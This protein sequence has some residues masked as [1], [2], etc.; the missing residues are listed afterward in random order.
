MGKH[1]TKVVLLMFSKSVKHGEDMSFRICGRAGWV[2]SV[3]NLEK[4]LGVA[5][6]N[7]ISAGASDI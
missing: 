7:M 4:L 2:I 3:S 6:S 1:G 5:I